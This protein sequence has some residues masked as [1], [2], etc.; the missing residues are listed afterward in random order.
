MNYSN[1]SYSP[2]VGKTWF[3]QWASEPS[4]SRFYP[5]NVPWEID[6]FERDNGYFLTGSKVFHTDDGGTNWKNIFSEGDT[7]IKGFR[8]LDKN[9]ILL[10]LVKYGRKGDF[11]GKSGVEYSPGFIYFEYSKIVTNQDWRQT[12]V[13]KNPLGSD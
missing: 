7:L 5:K 4:E 11:P 13:F 12:I 3:K 8:Y 2:D 6:F 9:R 10:N 1:F